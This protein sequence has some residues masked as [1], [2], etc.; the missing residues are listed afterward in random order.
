M[1]HCRD[2][3]QRITYV[4]FPLQVKLSLKNA[5]QVLAV[6]ISQGISCLKRS[7]S[8]AIYKAPQWLLIPGRFNIPNPTTAM[9]LH[10]SS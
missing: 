2:N 9:L 10:E 4:T 3:K 6:A 5:L 7:I 1:N 8:I